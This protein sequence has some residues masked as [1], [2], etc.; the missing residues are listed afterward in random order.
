MDCV[1]GGQKNL[2][3]EL[4][5]NSRKPRDPTKNWL[6]D[7]PKKAHFTL[8]LGKTKKGDDVVVDDDDIMMR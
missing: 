7:S 3:R 2:K 4:E 1:N 8:S 6:S 5:N